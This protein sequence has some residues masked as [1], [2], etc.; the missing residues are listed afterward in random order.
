MKRAFGPVLQLL[1]REPGQ[2]STSLYM[3]PRLLHLT[4]LGA[5]ILSTACSSLPGRGSARNADFETLQKTLQK[6]RLK[7]GQVRRLARE[8]LSAEIIRSK[9]REDRP[10]ISG[11][12]A[13][14][15][16]LFPA[17]ETRAK[18]RDGVGAEAALLLLDGGRLQGARRRFAEE[19]DG[20]WRALSARASEDDGEMRRRYFTD[21]D[22]RVRRAALLAALEARDEHDI[23]EL[24]SVAR[25]DP[26]PLS[27]SR[28]YQV[29]GSIGGERV[30]LALVD[31]FTT[32]DEAQRLAIV[33]AWAKPRLYDQGGRR[34]L[35]RLLTHETGFDALYAA[36]I[37]SRDEDET[38]RNRGINRLLYFTKEGT[39]EERRMA[40]RL[41]PGGRKGTVL[42]LVELTESKDREVAVIAT[43]RLLGDEQHRDMAQ[44]MLL[45]WAREPNSVG[46]QARSALSVTG[47]ERILPFMKQQM[48]SES[49][50]SRRVAGAALVRLGA[51]TELAPLLADEDPDV[52]RVV[53]CQA[54]ARAPLPLE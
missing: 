18:T 51:Y 32:A 38:L 2:C 42:R 25:L 41:L 7:P 11:L 9:D 17:L 12:G 39:T 29:L 14:S 49:P 4:V 47:D 33:D 46:F 24:L 22:E 53:A 13:C 40:A 43:A 48:K 36:S 37:L 10:F 45:K 16:P 50:E 28:A 3:H 20:A 26:D 34:N 44:S 31:R 15:R 23:E 52:R 19:K 54:L 35:T 5:M 21:V 6:E 30:A 1:Y 27:Q 8:V